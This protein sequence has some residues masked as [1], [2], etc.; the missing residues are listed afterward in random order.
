MIEIVPSLLSADFSALGDQ[1]RSA[2]SEGV[3]RF[4]VD[5][6]DGRFVPNLSM[7]PHVVRSLRPLTEARGA[8]LDVHLMV[9]RPEAFVAVF[10]DAG[11][12]AIS[13]HV[14]ATP[15]LERVVS[16]I[17]ERGAEAGV[18][19]NPATPLGALEE[20]LPELD[21]VLIMSVNPGFAAQPFLPS[22]APKIARLRRLLKERGLARVAIQVDGGIHVETIA[23]VAQAGAD[24]AVAGSAV[25]EGE[26]SIAEKFARLRAA[27][28]V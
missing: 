10:A 21:F 6:M 20:I 11:A 16:Q 2:L 19:I 26:G 8:K 5:I 9:E 17:R 27:A 25:F 13:V 12:A 7:G 14:E 28:R 24:R 15:H 3:T 22:A 1:L 23:Q 4:H 18:A